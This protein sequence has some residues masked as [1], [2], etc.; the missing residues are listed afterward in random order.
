VLL[1]GKPG[2]HECPGGGEVQ[3]LATADALRKAGAMVCCKSPEKGDLH[4]IDCLHLFGSLPEHVPT[5]E[6]ARKLNVPVVLSTIAWFDPLARFREGGRL[7][8]RVWSTAKLLARATLPEARSWRDRLYRLVDL[9]L[10]NSQAEARQLVRYFAVPRRKIRIVPNAACDHFAGASAAP[11]EQEFGLR[12]FVLCPGRIEP[13]KN[14]LALIEALRG[15]GLCLVILGQPAVGFEWYFRR[16]RQRADENVVFLPALRHDDPLLASAY[17]AAD[18][19]V[20]CS[21]FETPGLAALEAAL[22]GTH[23]VVPSRGSARE[24]F[25]T[26]AEYADPGDLRSIRR[27]VLRARGRK[28]DAKLARHVSRHFTW[29]NAAAATLRA[30]RQALG[31]AEQRRAPKR[32]ARSDPAISPGLFE[33]TMRRT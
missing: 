27:S 17:A 30:Y 4:G 29:A 15:S 10:P 2:A 22:C 20:L 32:G 14:Q 5:V 24:Y 13:R 25:D 19:V 7:L 9:L 6:A 3:M 31:A 12:R 28:P 21:W 1:A 16:C 33:G 11:F 23:V 18:C 26:L 8:R